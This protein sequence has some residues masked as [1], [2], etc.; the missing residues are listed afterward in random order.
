MVCYGIF[1]S[2]QLL[3][4]PV[5]VYGIRVGISLVEADE[6][7]GQICHFGLPAKDKKR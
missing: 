1:W 2:G 4:V 7:E 5:L 6:R 3:L